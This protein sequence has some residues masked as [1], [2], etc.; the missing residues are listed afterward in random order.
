[1]AEIEGGFD[2]EPEL[3]ELLSKASE[4]SA[5]KTQK[6]PMSQFTVTE[7]INEEESK[8]QRVLMTRHSRNAEYLEPKSRHS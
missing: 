4:V 8:G 2:V 6:R 5:S 3:S 7:N 1:M